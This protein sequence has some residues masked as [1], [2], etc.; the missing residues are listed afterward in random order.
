MPA[1][2]SRPVLLVH[3]NCQGAALAALLKAHPPCADRYEVQHVVN[4]LRRPFPADLLPRTAIY[5][6]Q[7]LEPHWDDHASAPLLARLPAASHAICFPNL[8]F[9]G[10][11]PL[12]TGQA[13]ID[14]K[15]IFLET[16]LAKGLADREIQH[17]ACHSDLTRFFDLEAIWAE[18]LAV[19]QK[20]ETR[21]DIPADVPM[22]SVIASDFRHAPLF[23]TINHPAK[24]LIV[25]IAQALCHALALPP[26][27]AGTLAAMAEPFGDFLLPVHP[28]VAALQGLTWCDAGTRFPCYGHPITHAEYVASYLYCRRQGI[29]D[30]IGFLQLRGGRATAG[31][32][33]EDQAL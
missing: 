11:W 15:D 16:L 26:I 27:A 25:R 32:G 19:E 1:S 2:A 18:S 8:F 3:S 30:L 23:Y 29:D 7:H 21:W 4:H 24:A 33:Q 9:K 13:G 12:W 28:Q 31:D 5:C 22:T 14:F 20:K 10:Y 17:L 6:Y